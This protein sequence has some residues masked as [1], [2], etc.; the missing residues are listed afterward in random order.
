M[1]VALSE[2]LPL[3]VM[4]SM[5]SDSR[6]GPDG[7]ERGSGCKK[8]AGNRQPGPVHLETEPGQMQDFPESAVGQSESP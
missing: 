6:R 7:P 5:D 3:L 8:E 2:E 4:G 1:C